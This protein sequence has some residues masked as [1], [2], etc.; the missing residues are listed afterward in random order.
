MNRTEKLRA[1]LYREKAEYEKKLA[2]VS[3]DIAELDGQVEESVPNEI[4]LKTFLEGGTSHVDWIV[5]GV[6]AAGTIAMMAADSK[7]GKTTMLTQVSLCLSV[8]LSPFEGWGVPRRRK[9]LYLIAEG[10]R[11]AFRSRVDTA[12]IAKNIPRDAEWF[13]QREGFVDFQIGSRGLSSIVEHSRAD[14]VTLDTMRYFYQGDENSSDDWMRY[15][16]LPLR[17][18]AQIEAERRHKRELRQSHAPERKTV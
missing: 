2:D 11:A 10:S 6:L 7:L 3:G 9:T 16:M 15:V 5:T 4:P 8:G 13:V 14:L 18:I 12:R 1:D 17:Q